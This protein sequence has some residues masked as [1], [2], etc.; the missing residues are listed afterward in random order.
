MARCLSPGCITGRGF[1]PDVSKKVL[2]GMKQ[3]LTGLGYPGWEEGEGCTSTGG[4]TGKLT[5]SIGD[6][7][8]GRR[9]Q[10]PQRTKHCVSLKVY[11][12]VCL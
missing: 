12:Y 6:D 5:A 11:I 10:M 4:S 3:V 7:G 1:L 9:G 8:E 2:S